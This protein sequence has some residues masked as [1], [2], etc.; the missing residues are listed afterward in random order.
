MAYE[1]RECKIPGGSL[2]YVWRIGNPHALHW[3]GHLTRDLAVNWA[4]D[5]GIR[6]DQHGKD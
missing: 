1:I 3:G 5:R 4:T 6:F 2:W